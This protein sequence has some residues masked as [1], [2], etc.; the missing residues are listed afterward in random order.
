MV[1]NLCFRDSKIFE[2]QLF[3]CKIKR[4][5]QFKIPSVIYAQ[6]WGASN[7]YQIP[8]SLIFSKGVV[9]SFNPYWQFIK[10]FSCLRSHVIGKLSGDY[11]MS[12]YIAFYNYRVLSHKCHFDFTCFHTF[13]FIF[14]GLYKYSVR[15][16]EKAELTFSET[17]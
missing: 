6:I 11:K 9:S 4:S 2:A 8:G 17:H 3:D 1:K 14:F 15:C 7:Q 13:Y 16:T 10:M 12:H 5:P